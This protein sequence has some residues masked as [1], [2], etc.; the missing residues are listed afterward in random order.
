MIFLPWSKELIRLVRRIGNTRYKISKKSKL[1]DS[2]M[3]NEFNIFIL[4]EDNSLLQTW[5]I[6]QNVYVFHYR[7]YG[8]VEIPLCVVNKIKNMCNIDNDRVSFHL[9]KLLINKCKFPKTIHIHISMR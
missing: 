6:E 5:K 7:D 1:V 2:Y 9:K 8:L 4:N 3:D